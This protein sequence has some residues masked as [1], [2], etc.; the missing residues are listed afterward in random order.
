LRRAVRDGV[1]GLHHRRQFRIVDRDQI[2]GV[3][4]LGLRRR[5]YHHNPLADETHPVDRQ[6]HV[7]RAI[8]FRAAHI[9]RHHLWRDR[10]HAVAGIIMAGEDRDHPGRGFRRRGIDGLDVRMGV[11]GIDK[12]RMGLPRQFD[13]ADILPSPGQEPGIFFSRNRLSD[14][15]LHIVSPPS[16]KH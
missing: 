11:G 14:T 4:G 16:V 1:G 3:M 12:H 10:A 15:E 7:S 8:A 2:G 6:G 5:D 9:F 13:V